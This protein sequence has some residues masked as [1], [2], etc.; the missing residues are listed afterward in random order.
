MWRLVFLLCLCVAVA[1]TAQSTANPGC[2]TLHD[3]TDCL[4]SSVCAYCPISGDCVQWD[5]CHDRPAGNQREAGGQ[6]APQRCSADPGAAHGGWVLPFGH[7]T[8]GDDK[9]TAYYVLIVCGLLVLCCIVVV[10]M[11]LAQ[12]LH[13]VCNATHD[14][15]ERYSY[16]SL[17]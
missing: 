3:H 12:A 10:I 7:N 2:D 6:H 17:Q 14:A 8:C 4:A 13:A 15:W 16:S 11:M 5:P 9:A 1:C